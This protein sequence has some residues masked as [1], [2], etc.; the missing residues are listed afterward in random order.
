[1]KDFLRENWLWIATPIVLVVAFLI[2]VALVFHDESFGNM[3]Y[4][5][6]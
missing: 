3:V 2:I 1:M 6:W 5:L 4:G